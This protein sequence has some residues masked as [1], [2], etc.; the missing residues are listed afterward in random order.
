VE[1]FFKHPK[2]MVAL[3][4]AITVFFAL[5]L[6][7]IELDNNNFR[8]L[9][10]DVP[11]RLISDH[12]E[13][14]F[15]NSV[16]IMVGLE[17]ETGSVFD[18]SFLTRIQE[19]VRRI[20]ELEFV[21]DVSSIMTM[22]YITA[23]G[24]AILVTDLVDE[25]FAGTPEE[26]AELKRR[27]ASWNIYEGAIVSEDLSAT[28]ILIPIDVRQADAGKSEVVATLIAARD[29]ARE[30]F[31][32]FAK[33][34]VTG[35]PVM[36]ATITESAI[37]DV[38][39]LVPLM[40]VVLL[41]VL[42][43]TFRRASGV[44]LP[45]LT[46]V[47][48]VI[49]PMGLTP[50]LGIKLSLIAV[51]MP[52]ILAAVGSAYGIHV[53]THYLEETK[54]RTLSVDEH[55]ALIFAVIRKII[56]PV[57]LAALT[58]LAGFLSFCFTPVVPIREFGIISSVGVM[59][60]FILSIT[61]IPACYLIQGPRTEK[62][63]QNRAAGARQAE[64]GTTIAEGFL[65]VA[66]HRR[67]VL[68]LTVIIAGISVWGSTKLIIDNV[69]VEYFNENTDISRSDRFIREKFG[70]SKSVNIALEADTTEALLDPKALGAMDE[71]SAALMERNPLVGKIV[72]F[73]DMI[74]RINQ[75]F[76]ADESPLGL[77]PADPPQTD[78]SFGFGF[79][80]DGEDSFGFGFG[81]DDS[82][83]EEFTGNATG[84]DVTDEN[85]AGNAAIL[86][87]PLTTAELLS[88]LDTASGARADMKAK[89]LVRSLMRQTNYDGLAYYEI[90]RDPAKYGK[91][92]DAELEGIIANYLALLAGD[93]TDYSN[94]PM[95]P[96]AI[97]ST[98]QLRTLGQIDTMEVVN[99]INA[100]A[101]EA[102]PDTVRFTVGGGSM[103]EVA[104]TDLMIESQLITIAFSVQ[105]VFVIIAM[106]NRS[107]AAGLICGVPILIAIFCNFAVMGVLGIKLN[108]AT[109]IIASLIVGIGIDYTI[110]FLDAFKFE[111]LARKEGEDDKEVLRRAFKSSGKAIITNAVSVGA[112]FAVLAFSDFQIMA[113]M[114]ILVAFAMIIT[115]LLSL[116]VIPA[117]LVT[118]RPKFI[119]GG[120]Q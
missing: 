100:Y 94:D 29:T 47:I 79:A 67:L 26:I 77:G 36:S 112:G 83:T 101:E 105:M 19:Y 115:S 55:R 3:I 63:K 93:N 60:A 17:R 92:T 34:Y 8:F 37:H 28:Q 73:P 57:F 1:K 62:A 114:G 35:A 76:N 64:S 20:E 6:P 41:G 15:G 39:L 68:V 30:M 104:L 13:E 97:Q 82:G 71:I 75:V 80:G 44:I 48:A 74:K 85:A 33:V 86:A 87:A 5:Q 108:I 117:L 40:L 43:F 32:E 118:V 23:R 4:A 59:S 31:E 52:M 51:M 113:D 21:G 45:F 38:V 95:E 7:R 16:S 70:G 18:P 120:K 107:L 109:A 111:Y 53:V 96:T 72:G 65:S 69:T 90:P 10:D 66:N 81:F 78:D 46:V 49:W 88:M 116:T 27:I 98:V 2:L 56:K 61:L 103:L 25:G 24:D 9:P 14:T 119:Y 84:A 91:T 11:A 42:I 54:G 99:A 89:D 106:S 50:L 58:T 22:D 110:H 12:F 102:F